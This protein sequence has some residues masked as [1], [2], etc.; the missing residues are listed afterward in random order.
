MIVDQIN[1]SVDK[2]VLGVFGGTVTVAIYSVGGQINTLYLN[3][4]TAVSS[5]F[6]PRVNKIIAN[7]YEDNNTLSQLFTKVGRI[8][9]LILSCILFGFIILGKYFISIW[10]GYEY[11]TAYYVAL[12]LII[13][14]T[15]P[16]IQ[17]LG[18]EIQRA[19]NLHKF[20][21]IVY[22][23]IAIGNIFISIPLSMRFGEIGAAIG[24]AIALIIGN[25]VIMNIYYEKVVNLNMLYFWKEIFSLLP[26][27]LCAFVLGM[28]IKNIIGVSSI[29]DFIIVGF[30]YLISFIILVCKFGLNSYEKNL[31]CIQIK[32]VLCKK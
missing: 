26:S 19:K 16:L 13:P 17:N 18:I 12:I 21:S 4:S 20:R 30:L 25:I 8:Q 9:F 5:V 27:V 22:L 15:I 3:L 7:D 10:A 29:V 14:V 32:K 24:T 1:W 11:H 28:L 2:Y 31:V 23:F 6:I